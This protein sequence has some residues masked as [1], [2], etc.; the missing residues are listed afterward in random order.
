MK[1]CP[2]CRRDYYD[3]SL[4][5][6]L[7]DG[8]ALLD[9]PASAS[10]RD[11]PQTAILHDIALPS[12]GK[13]LE[14]VATTERT[15]DFEQ[16]ASDVRNAGHDL[17]KWLLAG[18]A[19]LVVIAL[20]SFLGY[21]YLAAVSSG[22]IN[23]I[24][25]MPFENRSGSPDADYLSDGL[26]DSLIFRFSQL[27]NLKVSPTSSVMRY[28]GS[29]SDVAQV[30]K[31]LNVDAVL[32]GRLMQVGDALSISVQLIEARSNKVLWAEQYD[33]KMA[34]L[35]ATQREI[36]K[37]ITEKLQLK[38]SGT[39][40][41]VAKKYTN[42]SEAYQL[43]LKGR[44]YWAKRTTAD[45]FKA[46]DSYKQAIAIDPNFAL[47]YAAMA[48]VYNSMAKDP[49]VAPKDAVPFAKTAA[50][51]ALE[52]DPS[53]PEA[54]SAFGDSLAIYDW[55]WP[56][57]ERELQK[58]LQLDPNIGYIHLVY[59]GSYLGPVGKVDQ[60]VTEAERAVELEPLSLIN[61]SVLTS[62][63]YYARQYDKAIAQGRRSV[64]LDPN[65]PLSR[66]WLAMAFVQSGQYD[67]A[68]ATASDT[69]KDS[70]A[71]AMSMVALGN[72]YARMGK[73]AEAEQQIAALRD[74]GKTRYTRRYY[75]A[76]IY[77]SMGEKD[78]AF[79]ELEH[80]FEERDAFLGRMRADP[81]MDPIRND[82]R[83]DAMLRRLNL[84][85]TQ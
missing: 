76:L 79:E 17:R 1:R 9:G 67:A 71:Y 40:A 69:P 10:G 32:N 51:R 68:I 61:N 33:R 21:R 26:T 16:G 84:L 38:L 12:E 60:S 28:K 53:L 42:S 50:T 20:S 83:F 44:F 74:L 78:K 27:P 55:N 85:S 54:H 49:D 37:T 70:T 3:D 77:A 46:I 6:C 2:D 43:Y 19:M 15:A 62:A 36:A 41:G 35:L 4:L 66:F 22:S 58:A 39:E 59:S 63:Y 30:A 65:F 45:M 29:T 34:D 25:V 48:E 80:C 31:E 52:L 81:S 14:Q 5:Y 47:A 75:I 56:E 7:D 13:T 8:A 73:K 82:P 11:E 24:A 64:E 72:V 18:V 57:S 23:S